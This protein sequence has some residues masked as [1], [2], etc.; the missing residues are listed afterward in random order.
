[1][2]RPKKGQEQG[3]KKHFLVALAETPY[4]SVACKAAQISRSRAY[5][6]KKE[7]EDF[8]QA[9]DMAMDDGL[10]QIE[11]KLYQIGIGELRGQYGALI[12]LLKARRY[13]VKSGQDM[14]SQITFT[15]GPSANGSIPNATAAQLRADESDSEPKQ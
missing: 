6:A 15:W 7:D 3:W 12:Y 4:V 8:A 5:A 2:A 1:M 10:D 11:H 9:W 14:P 13:E